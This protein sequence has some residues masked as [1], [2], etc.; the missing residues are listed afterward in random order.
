MCASDLVALGTAEAEID[1]LKEELDQARAELKQTNFVLRMAE[2]HHHLACQQRDQARKEL[3]QANAA[4]KIALI[5]RDSAAEAAQSLSLRERHALAERDEAKAELTE[6]KEQLE[7]VSS[8]AVKEAFDNGLDGVELRWKVLAEEALAE[9]DQ[10]REER[11]QANHHSDE[12]QKLVSSLTRLR[13][14][15]IKE[16]EHALQDLRQALADRG[17][18]WAELDQAN[19]AL[20]LAA[21]VHATLAAERDEAL[22][23]NARLPASEPGESPLRNAMAENIDNCD[24]CRG[25]G[26]IVCTSCGGDGRARRT[27]PFRLERLIW[28]APRTQKQA[29]EQRF[30]DEYF[31]AEPKNRQD[32]INRLVAE[33][34]GI[35]SQHG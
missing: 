26:K 29:L 5:E 23:N 7:R 17:Q 3:E 21:D 8:A 10:A 19:N 35:C 20:K 4:L 32:V 18:A 31:G 30:A 2:R 6:L 12:Q 13:D 14:Q 16:R 34:S 11:D 22:A 15:A 25:T 33:H 9:R 24:R 28:F 27:L 1:R